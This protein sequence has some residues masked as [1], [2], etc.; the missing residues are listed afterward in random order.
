MLLEQMDGDDGV[1]KKNQDA[2]SCSSRAVNF[3]QDFWNH[4]VQGF[5]KFHSNYCSDDLHISSLYLVQFFCL[6]KKLQYFFF[7]KLN[8]QLKHKV[9]YKFDSITVSLRTGS[10]KPFG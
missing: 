10:I 9:N 4:S 1:A 6:K 2:L 8:K 5:C 3:S 7:C